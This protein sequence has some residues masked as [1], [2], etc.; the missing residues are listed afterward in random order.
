MEQPGLLPEQEGEQEEQEDEQEQWDEEPMPH[1]TAFQLP[2]PGFCR[3][4]S[5]LKA[6]MYDRLASGEYRDWYGELWTAVAEDYPLQA[7]LVRNENLPFGLGLLS[8]NDGR[9]TSA[10]FFRVAGVDAYPVAYCHMV[11]R[12][13]RHVWR[14]A[15]LECMSL[16]YSMRQKIGQLRGRIAENNSRIEEFVQREAELMQE[17]AALRRQLYEAQQR[18]VRLIVHVGDNCAT[19]ESRGRKRCRGDE[20]ARAVAAAAG[21]HWCEGHNDP[22]YPPFQRFSCDPD[23]GDA[24][25]SGSGL[26]LS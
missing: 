11:T 26:S 2:L 17:S 1:W 10:G 16:W 20:E 3:G 6:F 21:L 15:Q 13:V 5:R 7:E 14:F 25:A 24:G 19:A 23:L 9:N 22:Q 4:V 18:Q 8:V 12:L